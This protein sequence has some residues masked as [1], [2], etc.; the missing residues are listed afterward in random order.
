LACNTLR[1]VFGSADG[2]APNTPE[3][4]SSSWGL[5]V[6]D[7]VRMHVLLLGQLGQCLLAANG[8]QRHFRLECWWVIA[9]GSSA[10]AV[11]SLLARLS[12]LL[13]GPASTC[14]CVQISGATSRLG[15]RWTHARAADSTVMM[16]GC[17]RTG[18]DGRL[19]L[20]RAFRP[21]FRNSTES[22]DDT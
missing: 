10:S 19:P 1:S 20:A 16:N 9:A 8:V 3:T 6:R 2:A 12:S 7:L 22:C 13:R 14:R 18:A 4:R 17:N 11:I 15:W 21:I 5:P